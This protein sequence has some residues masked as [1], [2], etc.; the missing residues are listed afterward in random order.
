MQRD[1]RASDR[2]KIHLGQEA[3]LAEIVFSL[4]FLP[5]LTYS[6]LCVHLVPFSMLLTKETYAGLFC[7]CF[8]SDKP[9]VGW[10]PPSRRLWLRCAVDCTCGGLGVT[11][12]K[13]GRH[14]GAGLRLPPAVCLSLTSCSSSLHAGSAAVVLD[15]YTGSI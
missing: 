9:R 8:P 14:G 3:L 5:L 2:Q 13:S 15:G 6:F 1:V 10:R 7:C 12:V 4:E 11:A